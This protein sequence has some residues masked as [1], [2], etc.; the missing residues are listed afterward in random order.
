MNTSTKSQNGLWSYQFIYFLFL[1]ILSISS[2]TISNSILPLYIVDHY[3]G[4]SSQVGAISSLVILTALVFRPFTGYLVDRWGRK[5]TLMISFFLMALLHF[6]VLIPMRMEGLGIVRFLLGFPY[7]LFTTATS[8]VSADILPEE[9]RSYG[10]GVI[11]IITM[12]SGVVLAPNLGFILLG[13]GNFNLIFMISGVLS[14]LTILVVL[15]MPYDD[16]Q[17]RNAKFSFNS[18][19]EQNA[20]FIAVILGLI[21]LGM[22]GLFTFGPL[23]SKE[24]GITSV[25]LFLL[26]YGGGLLVAQWLNKY[27]IDLNN[28]RRGGILSIGLL[29]TG[30]SAIGIF[31]SK[32]G[33]FVGSGLVGIGY[34]LVFAIFAPMA[35]RLVKPSKR[36]AC[37]ATIIFGQDIGSFLGLYLFSWF[38]QNFGSYQRSYLM[39]GLI[40]FIPLGIFI[41]FCLPHYSRVL[42]EEPQLE[43]QIE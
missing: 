19:F 2:I 40:M 28:P 17:N 43:K 30:Y 37:N 41:F 11:S 25:G 22:P 36:G 32:F 38:I 14:L 7:S 27:L 8:T 20:S 16:I 10:F 35:L 23:Y 42:K 34:G 18:T 31:N 3:H 39:N 15:R 5:N 1:K 26:F 4:S 12:L 9:H 13:D 21:L 29:L 24:L 6:S 33:F